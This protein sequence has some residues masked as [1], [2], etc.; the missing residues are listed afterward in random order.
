MNQ[1]KRRSSKS[2]VRP[3]HAVLLLCLL[4]CVTMLQAQ[5]T[6]IYVGHLNQDQYADTVTGKIYGGAFT[7]LPDMIIWGKDHINPQ[8]PVGPPITHFIYPSYPHFAGSVS[9]LELNPNDTLADMLFF[10]WGQNDTNGVQPDTGRAVAIFGQT[11]LSA[12]PVIDFRQI[13]SGF[14]ATPFFAQDVELGRHLTEPAVRDLSDIESY[15][16]LPI[17]VKVQGTPPPPIVT[18]VDDSVEV[19]IYPNPSIYTATIEAAL[20]A[21]NYTARVVAVNGQVYEEQSINLDNS[22]TLWR[23]IDVSRLVSGHYVIQLMRSG[24]TVGSYPFIIKR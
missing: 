13:Q 4:C 21:G 24:Q 15:R 7:R 17:D 10:L 11:A 16:L 6:V 9:F 12:M 8:P 2:A 14:Q 1:R 19:R 5:P 22:G 18:H 20:P 3:Y 23:S